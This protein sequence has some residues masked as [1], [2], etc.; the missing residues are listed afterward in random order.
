MLRWICGHTRRD[1]V[2]N[3]DIRD[4]LEVAPIEK[5]L[6]QHRLRWFGHVQRRPLEAPVR[7][8]ILSQ[9]SNVKRGR[10]RPM[11][12]W[13]Q[14]IKGDLKGWNIPNDLALDRSACKTAIHVPEL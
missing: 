10:G 2:Q 6:V 14:A 1:R 3:D 8:G 11:L 7:S 13:V 5:K 12:T 4:R 9:D